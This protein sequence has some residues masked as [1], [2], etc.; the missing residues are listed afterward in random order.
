MNIFFN[1]YFTK[2]NW[3]NKTI[4]I[5][6]QRCLF[7]Q[8]NN[9]LLC[10]FSILYFVTT[11][12]CDNISATPH[13]QAAIITVPPFT[14]A[15]MAKQFT[16]SI[17]LLHL[18]SDCL[19]M[20]GKSIYLSI[21]LLHLKDCHVSLFLS[22]AIKIFPI[23]WTWVAMQFTRWGIDRFFITDIVLPFMN[24]IPLQYWLYLYL[25]SFIL[26]GFKADTGSLAGSWLHPESP[27]KVTYVPTCCF[28]ASLP[29]PFQTIPNH[30]ISVYPVYSV[31]PPNP[32]LTI[33]YHTIS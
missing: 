24:A 2:Y 25:S 9:N 16:Y 7:F 5:I 23:A 33:P 19:D 17:Y 12:V 1:N 15:R 27:I 3:M 28:A 13:L 20:D 8:S 11:V 4:D 32:Y 26:C 18:F 14:I 31:Y 30:I 6:G 22:T 21:H 29:N 10:V